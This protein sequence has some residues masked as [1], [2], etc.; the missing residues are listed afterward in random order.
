MNTSQL[1]FDTSQGFSRQSAPDTVGSCIK[2]G[3]IWIFKPPFGT[4]KCTPKECANLDPPNGTLDTK[5]LF[6]G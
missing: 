5:G 4:C 3:G 1:K 6:W 2:L